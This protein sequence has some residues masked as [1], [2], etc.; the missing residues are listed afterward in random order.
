MYKY[1]YISFIS[2]GQETWTVLTLVLPSYKTTLADLE[3][4]E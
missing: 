3:E 4:I 1:I 2:V